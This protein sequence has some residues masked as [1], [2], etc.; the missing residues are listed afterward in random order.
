[1]YVKLLHIMKLTYKEIPYPYKKKMQ[2]KN[3][4]SN[5]CKLQCLLSG[6]CNYN[7]FLKGQFLTEYNLD[8]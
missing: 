4:F 3:Y 2:K 8:R 5:K 7:F 6:N 1:M